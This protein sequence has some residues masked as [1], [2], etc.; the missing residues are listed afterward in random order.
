MKYKLTAAT[1]AVA[2]FPAFAATRQ[3]RLKI[4]PL[5]HHQYDAMLFGTTTSRC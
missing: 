5:R 4:K 3:Q 2:L 1:L